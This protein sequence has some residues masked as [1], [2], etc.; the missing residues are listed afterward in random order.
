MHYILR[1]CKDLAKLRFIPVCIGYFVYFKMNLVF[2]QQAGY[3]LASV[4]LTTLLMYLF[5]S[6]V[7]P[8]QWLMCAVFLDVKLA[9]NALRPAIY[10]LKQ[11][12]LFKFPVDPILKKK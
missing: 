3:L 11:F 4:K 5:I 8:M 6:T 2:F 1:C 12:L 7:L 9:I 10:H